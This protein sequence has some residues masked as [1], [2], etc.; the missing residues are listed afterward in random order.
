MFFGSGFLSGF[1]Q[2]L[3]FGL[4]LLAGSLFLACGGGGGCEA[5]VLLHLALGLLAAA[6]RFRDQFVGQHQPRIADVCHRQQD[7]GIFVLRHVIA[8]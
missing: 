2:F 4:L 8:M 5:E 3:G 6:H 7:V 1:V